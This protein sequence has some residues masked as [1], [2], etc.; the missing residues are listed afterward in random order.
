MEKYRFNYAVQGVMFC[1][2]PWVFINANSLE[3]AIELAKIEILNTWKDY[4]VFTL[5]SKPESIKFER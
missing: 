2:A 3:E 1:I 5:Y 4:N